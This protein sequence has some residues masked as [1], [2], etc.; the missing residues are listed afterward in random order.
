MPVDGPLMAVS[1]PAVYVVLWAPALLIVIVTGPSA[2]S[3]A[4]PSAEAGCWY[5]SE[6]DSRAR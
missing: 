5:V 1:G 3:R 2:R 6:T 4:M